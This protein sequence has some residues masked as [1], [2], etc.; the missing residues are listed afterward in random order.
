MDQTTWTAGGGGWFVLALVN[1]GLAEQKN[2]SRLSWFLLSLL[3]GPFATAFIVMSSPPV[4]VTGSRVELTRI[5]AIVLTVA[6]IACSVTFVILATVYNAPVLYFW[7]AI[8]AVGAVL[9][10]ILLAGIVRKERES[11][12]LT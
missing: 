11:R 4:A 1:A 6:S 7:T 9:S 5:G 8:F 10:G 2:R 3:F 12:P